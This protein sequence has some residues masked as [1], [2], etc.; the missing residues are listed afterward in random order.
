MIRGPSVSDLSI[1]GGRF[2]LAVSAGF[3]GQAPDTHGSFGALDVDFD[4]LKSLM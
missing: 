1:S 3:L 2:N 4:G